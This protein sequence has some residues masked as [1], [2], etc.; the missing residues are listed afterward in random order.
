MIQYTQF[1]NLANTTRVYITVTGSHEAQ[2][3]LNLLKHTCMGQMVSSE[4]TQY[5]T[6]TTA[7][8]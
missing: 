1:A 5:P 8:C 7:D 2:V 4:V 6:L 3:T